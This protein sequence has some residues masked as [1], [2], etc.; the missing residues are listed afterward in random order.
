MGGVSAMIPSF[1]GRISIEQVIS[2][3]RVRQW[4]GRAE[5]ASAGGPLLESGHG[6]S[7]SLY[8]CTSCTK[9]EAFSPTGKNLERQNGMVTLVPFV[10]FQ[11]TLSPQPQV[12]DTITLHTHRH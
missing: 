7:P 2:E 4:A 1:S 10:S 5:P 8:P 9:L 12:L 11:L 3:R 6:I